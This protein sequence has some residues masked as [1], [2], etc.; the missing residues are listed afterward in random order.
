MGLVTRDLAGARLLFRGTAWLPR[1]ALGLLGAWIVVLA[2][3][4]PADGVTGMPLILTV[5]VFVLLLAGTAAGF[6]WLGVA[7]EVWADDEALLV[8]LG[9]D[10]WRRVPWSEVRGGTWLHDGRVNGPAITTTGG[11]YD[12]PNPD[13]YTLLCQPMGVPG[14]RRTAAATLREELDRHGIPWSPQVEERWTETNWTN[15]RWDW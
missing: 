6:R 1:V 9:R 11:P 13:W 15:P 10:R 5:G 14:G 2:V 7:A 3:L 12:R 8:R 4:L